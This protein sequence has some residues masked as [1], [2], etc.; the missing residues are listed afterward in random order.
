MSDMRKIG[1]ASSARPVLLEC[2]EEIKP[3]EADAFHGRLPVESERGI[4]PVGTP[5]ELPI[6]L[7]DEGGNRP[8]LRHGA[9][10]SPSG[11]VLRNRLYEYMTCSIAR[12]TNRTMKAKSDRSVILQRNIVRIS[13]HPSIDGGGAKG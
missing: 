2:C 11:S 13:S 6:G 8:L 10:T 1:R 7:D 4:R 3:V 12:F 9:G 5:S